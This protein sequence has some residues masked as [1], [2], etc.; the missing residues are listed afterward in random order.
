MKIP[1]RITVYVHVFERCKVLTHQ[2][3]KRLNDVHEMH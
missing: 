2:S 1:N 3:G